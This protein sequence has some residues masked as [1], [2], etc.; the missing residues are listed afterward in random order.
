MTARI[1]CPRSFRSFFGLKID[2]LFLSELVTAAETGLVNECPVYFAAVH[3]LS[4]RMTLRA[5]VL[6]KGAENHTGNSGGH[7]KAPQ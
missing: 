7:N 5:V 1:Y 4:L 3:K 6:H 2:V